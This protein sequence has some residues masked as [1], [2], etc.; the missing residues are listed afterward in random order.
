MASNTRPESVQAFLHAAQRGFLDGSPDQK[1]RE[2]LSRVFDALQ[3]PAPFSSTETRRVS[4]SGLLGSAV[5]PAR[6]AGGA[7]E[8]LAQRILDLN[9]LLSWTRR[10]GA[11]PEASAGYA[12]GHANTMIVGPGGLEDRRDVWVGMSLMA[13]G[14]RY[15]VHRHSPEEVYLVLTDGQFLQGEREWFTPGV[16]GTLYNEPNILHAMEASPTA[17]FLALWCLFDARH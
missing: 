10:E 4:T 2:C 3:H 5:E 1:T 7:L 12:D 16:G 13:P 11:A 14:I 17:P 8:Q 15:P 6:R 9:S